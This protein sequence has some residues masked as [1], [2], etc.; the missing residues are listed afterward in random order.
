MSSDG[1][2]IA[3]LKSMPRLMA[4]SF[5][6]LVLACGCSG[7]APT[8]VDAG[9]PDT[10]SSAAEVA[11]ST[12]GIPSDVSRQDDSSESVAEGD[13]DSADFYTVAEYDVNANPK[14]QLLATL[15]RARAEDKTVLLQVG[16]EWCGWCKLM[17]K[18]MAE[19]Q[20]VN[21]RLQDSF[22]IQKVTYDPAN[23]NEAFLTNYPEIQGYPHLFV[24]DAEGNLLHSQNTSEL[25]EGDGYNETAFVAFLDRWNGQ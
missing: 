15:A 12:T 17:T 21:Q 4:I 10:E 9:T 8:L 6:S 24:L 16:G 2:S 13:S 19:N 22:L 1:I 25:E 7:E 11:T 20:E 3:R 14:D 5:C 23:R 18:F